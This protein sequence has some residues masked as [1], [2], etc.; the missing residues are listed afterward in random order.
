MLW[1]ER[2]VEKDTQV[3]NKA[4]SIEIILRLR[5]QS[6]VCLEKAQKWIRKRKHRQAK[7]L[8]E[9]L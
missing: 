7:G 6:L 9:N 4:I 1:L 2:T 8:L 5:L 3:K